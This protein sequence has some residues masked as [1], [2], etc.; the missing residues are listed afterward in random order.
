MEKQT[1]TSA[2]IFVGYETELSDDWLKIRPEFQAPKN[3]VKAETKE[4]KIAE[5]EAEYE[6]EACNYPWSGRIAKIVTVEPY[7]GERVF[8][9][10]EE[11]VRAFRGEHLDRFDKEGN[12][13]DGAV[14]FVGANIRTFVKMLWAQQCQVGP[15][16]PVHS[17]LPPGVLHTTHVDVGDIL[18][19]SGF[20]TCLDVDKIS[21]HY[22]MAPGS[23]KD[24]YQDARKAV[25]IALAYGLYPHLLGGD[26]K[27]LGRQVSAEATY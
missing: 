19:P 26:I 12:P 2:V 3:V 24:A 1:K 18:V 9:E 5:K 22:F 14:R 16:E 7:H 23:G 17:Q 13:V 10:A 21:S 20:K 25:E 11:F 8:D 27:M 6:R 15:V 4:K